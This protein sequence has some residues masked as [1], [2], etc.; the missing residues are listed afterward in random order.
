MNHRAIDARRNLRLRRTGFGRTSAPVASVSARFHSGCCASSFWC[1]FARRG[2]LIVRNRM[3]TET[4]MIAE[5]I[6]KSG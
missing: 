5:T 6:R 2:S 3:P 1:S 4:N